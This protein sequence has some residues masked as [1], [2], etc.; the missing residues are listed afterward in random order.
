MSK[1]NGRKG[2]QIV[3]PLPQDPIGEYY[4]TVD[5]RMEAIVSSQV[6][7]AV[8]EAMTDVRTA[9]HKMLLEHIGGE[10]LEMAKKLY[11]EYGRGALVVRH[12]DLE[13]L[14]SSESEP[15]ELSVAYQPQFDIPNMPPSLL[16][17]ELG[18]MVESYDVNQMFVFVVFSEDDKTWAYG[19]KHNSEAPQNNGE[20]GQQ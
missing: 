12:E 1:K 18:L 7:Q 8:S 17:Y 11:A 20:G 10:M 15:C 6:Y 14:A 13:R 3:Y 9:M 2:F 19:L 16:S 5:K 4:G